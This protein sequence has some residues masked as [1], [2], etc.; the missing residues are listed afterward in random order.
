VRPLELPIAPVRSED[1][2]RFELAL[3]SRCSADDYLSA[4]EVR[5]S[6]QVLLAGV[7]EAQLH[8]VIEGLRREF[9]IVIGA[10][11]V[12]YRETVKDRAEIDY[13]HK[14]QRGGGGEFARVSL[15]IEPL[16]TGAGFEF[17]NRVVRGGIPKELVPA[18]ESGIRGAMEQGPLVGYPMT[19]IKVT[20]LDGAFHDADSNPSTFEIVAREAFRQGV[21]KAHAAL[22]EPLMEV[23]ISVPDGCVRDVTHDLEKRRGR[24]VQREPGSDRMHLMALVPLSDLLGYDHALQGITNGKS[25]WSSKF[26]TYVVV[27]EGGTPP[28]F[29]G[30]ASL[31]G[32]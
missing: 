13:T 22:L 30:A 25:D 31:R 8:R 15:L 27:D 6:G 4:T 14:R 7:S 21:E 3:R 10:P 18:V 1:A 19:Y 28:R 32:S 5:D 24:I 12:A 29:L 23:E 17:V 11:Q 9:Q 26:T 20:L 2:R 16:R